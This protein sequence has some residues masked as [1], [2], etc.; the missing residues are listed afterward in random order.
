LSEGFIE[1]TRGLCCINPHRTLP[2]IF[3]GNI[4]L[5]KVPSVN[6]LKSIMAGKSSSCCQNSRI[7]RK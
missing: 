3:E 2:G 1:L 7:R 5:G 6:G 4:I